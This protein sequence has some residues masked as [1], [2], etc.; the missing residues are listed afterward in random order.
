MEPVAVVVMDGEELPISVIMSDPT[1]SCPPAWELTTTPKRSCGRPSSVGIR[2]YS[3]AIFS[4]QGVQY[5]Q[6]CGRIIG[7]QFGQPEAFLAENIT[8]HKP[9]MVRMLM[10]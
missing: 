4:T 5:S 7:Y 9:S 2:A 1:Q 6:V 10:E 8:I 3:S